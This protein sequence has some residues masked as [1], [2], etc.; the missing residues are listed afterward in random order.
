MQYF[1]A[2]N[3][4]FFSEN[5][6]ENMKPE[7]PCYMAGFNNLGQTFLYINIEYLHGDSFQINQRAGQ[8]VNGAGRHVRGGRGHGRGRG[9]EGDV[10][11]EEAV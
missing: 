7:T 10:G 2:N 8:R 3:C 1:A 6:E 5:K 4:R 11:M 9:A